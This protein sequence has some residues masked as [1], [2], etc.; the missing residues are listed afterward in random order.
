MLADIHSI[1]DQ[2]IIRKSLKWKGIHTT[3]GSLT[4]S[5]L[6]YDQLEKFIYHSFDQLVSNL[7]NAAHVHKCIL[8]MC[9]I[10][11]RLNEIPWVVPNNLNSEEYNIFINDLNFYLMLSGTLLKSY[12]VFKGFISSDQFPALTKMLPIFGSH[13]KRVKQALTSIPDSPWLQTVHSFQENNKFLKAI[14]ELEKHTLKTNLNREFEI[15]L[16]QLL[17]TFSVQLYTQYEEQHKTRVIIDINE[18]FKPFDTIPKQ[19]NIGY[20]NLVRAVFSALLIYG[21][22][23]SSKLI[24]VYFSLMGKFLSNN[25]FH[26]KA[27]IHYFKKLQKQVGHLTKNILHINPMLT[28]HLYDILSQLNQL[29]SV[30]E[31]ISIQNT[32][33]T[34]THNPKAFVKMIQDAINDGYI[35]LKGNSDVKPIIEFLCNFVQVKKQNNSGVLTMSS[36]LTYFKKANSGEL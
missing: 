30:T 4:D 3:T 2:I 32:F 17:P 24:P 18:R 35:S 28:I 33:I 11:S 5:R 20:R 7:E 14:T 15:L 12:S 13:P 36:L 6:L 23:I 10:K 31:P 19:L 1:S 8:N 27:E 16:N 9:S 26:I 34:W 29:K 22:G 21:D 25:Y